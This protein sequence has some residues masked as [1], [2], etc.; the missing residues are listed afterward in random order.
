MLKTLRRRAERRFAIIRRAAQR[1]EIA[2]R[3]RSRRL[4]MANAAAEPIREFAGAPSP[5]ARHLAGIRRRLVVADLGHGVRVAVCSR[6]V[7][8]CCRKPSSARTKRSRNSTRRSR[9]LSKTLSLAA[10]CQSSDLQRERRMNCLRRSALLR[11]P[12]ATRQKSQ[13]DT[14]V[15]AEAAKLNA[16]IAALSELKAQL[17]QQVASLIQRNSIRRKKISSAATDL[18]A[19][20]AAQVE[21]LNRQIAAVRDQLSKV[22]RRARSSQCEHQRQRRQDRRSR[23]AVES[24]T[25]QQG[26]SARKIPFGVFRQAAR[27]ARLT[28]GDIRVIG[29]RFVV[30]T[31]V[32][33]DTGSADLNPSAESSLDK[34]AQ[35][36]NAVSAEIPS[37]SRLGR[38]HRRPHRSSGRFTP[39]N[40]RRT[41][42]CLRRAQWR[43]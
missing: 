14:I 12:S 24:R 39:I 27:G 42:N 8:S 26:Q 36:L 17:E 5:H 32:L 25:R 13:L 4:S 3:A 9:N 2:C 28:R 6:S 34:L 35:T 33:F 40:F 41:G 22:V 16:D 43:S 37:N 20:S 31:D 38:A 10:R 7:S 11:T 15:N 1:T 19:K 21:L 30:P 23:R 18:N 29:D